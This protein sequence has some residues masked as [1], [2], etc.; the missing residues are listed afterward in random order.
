MKL[1]NRRG[2]SLVFLGF[3]VIIFVISYGIMFLLVPM[4]LGTFFSFTPSIT[5]PGWNAVNTETQNVIKWL[6]PLVPTVGIFI[7][8][9]KVL[10]VASV[11]GRD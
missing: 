8:V 3:S 6:V 10:M 4:I 1:K 5:D 7:F 11:R 9:I 2:S